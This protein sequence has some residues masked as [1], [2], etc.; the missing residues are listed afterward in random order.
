MKLNLSPHS[1]Q[2]TEY[3]LTSEAPLY[4]PLMIQI[5]SI[6]IMILD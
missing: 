4:K 1:L 6:M 2:I 5:L 3:E